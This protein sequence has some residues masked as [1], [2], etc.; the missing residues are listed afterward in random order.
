[1]KSSLLQLKLKLA[2]RADKPSAGRAGKVLEVPCHPGLS[3]P[4]GGPG[5]PGN[6]AVQARFTLS[7]SV[8]IRVCYWD[9]YERGR[10]KELFSCQ[11]ITQNGLFFFMLIVRKAAT[12]LQHWSRN[13][14][15]QTAKQEQ[16][17]VLNVRIRAKVCVNVKFNGQ[18]CLLLKL[19]NILCSNS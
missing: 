1:M 3:G 14:E 17:V 13:I 16:E 18:H 6:T 12:S 4:P 5:L 15:V 19:N 2:N 10:R 8:A 11:K 7:T 9:K